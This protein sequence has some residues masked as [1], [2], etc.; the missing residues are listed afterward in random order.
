MPFLYIV[1]DCSLRQMFISFSL[2]V[3]MQLFRGILRPVLHADFIIRQWSIKV[4][5]FYFM[6]H[7]V[8][9]VSSSSA[10]YCCYLLQMRSYCKLKQHII[11]FSKFWN[12]KIKYAISRSHLLKKQKKNI[13]NF[14][15][16]AHKNVLVPT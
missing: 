3:V 12:K 11:L 2:N 14:S 6:S 13:Q 8:H 5:G 16:K 15:R 10:S 1:Y 4:L 9:F 7:F